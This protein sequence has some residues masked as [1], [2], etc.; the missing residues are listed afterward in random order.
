VTTEYKSVTEYQ[1]PVN[2]EDAMKLT[3]FAM[4]VAPNDIV[5]GKMVAE[6]RDRA[7][8]QRNPRNVY[9]C[10]LMR[11]IQNGLIFGVWPS[12]K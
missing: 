6:A 2:E 7:K 3:D 9:V 4:K 12:R 1:Y 11:I 5:G 10:E 8:G